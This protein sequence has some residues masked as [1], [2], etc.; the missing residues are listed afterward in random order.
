MIGFIKTFL[1]VLL[2]VL[3][4]FT[5]PIW[6]NYAGKFEPV[7]ADNCRLNFAAISDIHMKDDGLRAFMLGFGLHDME[8]AASELD[9][10]VCAGDL[11][12]HGYAEEWEALVGA[13]E[14]YTPAKNIILAQGNHDTW[15][16]DEG[17]N[18]AREY[19][20]NYSEEI[21]GRRIENEYYSTKINGYTFIV[22]ASEYDHTD[23]YISTAQL[24]WLEVEMAKA[25][26][27]GKPIFVVSH[28]PINQSHGLPES[29]GDEEYEPDEG[30]MGDQS[31]AVEVILKKYNNV[32]LISGHIHLG[33]KNEDQN[34][35]YDYASVESDGS[36]HSVNLP[37]YMYPNSV[38]QVSNGTGYQFEVYDDRVEL[39]AR[40]YSA[41]AWYTDYNY[42][43]PLV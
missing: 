9:A 41:S 17:Y 23:M 20:I 22:L 38:G 31:D 25:A 15:T 37:A 14:G 43:I 10:L 26:V 27:D 39:R 5:F 19:F 34:A 24:A 40:C 16:E 18:L 4:V 28:W 33:L 2:A 8:N 12:D 32:F 11:T 7:D 36:F 3:N 13:F 42:T 1:S 6:G 30:G 29:W 35:K 21:T